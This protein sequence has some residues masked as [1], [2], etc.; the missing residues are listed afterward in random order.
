MRERENVQS[1]A[2]LLPDYMG[3][4]FYA[5]SPRFVADLNPEILNKLPAS[6][7]KVGVFVNSTPHEIFEKIRIYGLDTVQLHGNETPEDCQRLK[8]EVKV[9]K[10][11]PVS[12]SVD[13]KMCEKYLG[14]I[15]YFLF[16]TKGQYHGGNG[17]PFDWDVL[18][19]YKHNVPFI[20]SGGL[21]L[22]EI[23]ALPTHKFMVGIDLNSKFEIK[24]GLKDLEALE[25][26][27]NE[28]RN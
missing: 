8:S 11:I 1:I 13:F 6:I 27:F 20:L 14:A 10:A 28:I 21:G 3:F 24:P 9:I 7:K 4:I 22:E 12:D 16:D 18:K 25:R 23:V 26:G 5:K 2:G 15:D 19:S 17:V